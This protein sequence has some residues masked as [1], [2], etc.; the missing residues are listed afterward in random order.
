MRQGR[1][2]GVN[3][4]QS[5]IFVCAVKLR[6]K[7]GLAPGRPSETRPTRTFTY[8]A[9]VTQAFPPAETRANSFRRRSTATLG[10]CHIPC[11]RTFSRHHWGVPHIADHLVT[12]LVQKV[13]KVEA[14]ARCPSSHAERNTSIGFTNLMRHLLQTNKRSGSPKSRSI[15]EAH[16]TPWL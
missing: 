14:L 13:T 16:N 5:L 3:T 11:V 15:T 9:K 4:G 1:P 12:S 8:F 10:A 7:P 6:S 2:V